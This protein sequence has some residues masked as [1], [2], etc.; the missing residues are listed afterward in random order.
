MGGRQLET[1]WEKLQ[2]ALQGR[3]HIETTVRT[4]RLSLACTQIL[5]LL[6]EGS[7]L[8]SSGKDELAVW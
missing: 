1:N 2:E 3:L 4:R 5:R 8:A 7:E 6:M